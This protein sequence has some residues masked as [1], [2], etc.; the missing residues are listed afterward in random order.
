MKAKG[1]DIN[2]KKLTFNVDS[3]GYLSCS[4]NNLTSLVVPDGVKEVHCWK[5]GARQQACRNMRQSWI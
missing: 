4:N 3:N 2:G 1:I 5:R